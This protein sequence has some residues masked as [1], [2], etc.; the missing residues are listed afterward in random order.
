M[1]EDRKVLIFEGHD[2]PQARAVESANRRARVVRPA[3]S[4]RD[5]LI[6]C[7]VL[8]SLGSLSIVAVIVVA[9]LAAI[10]VDNLGYWVARKGG[11]ALFSL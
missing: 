2:Q 6:A 5:G 8:A 1:E 10:V 4:R 3:N 9:A 11:R 7:G